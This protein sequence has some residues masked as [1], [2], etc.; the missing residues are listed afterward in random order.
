[1]K[2]KV[3]L[4]SCHQPRRRGFA[5]DDFLCATTSHSG[6]FADA[7]LRQ[8]QLKMSR[9]VHRHRRRLPPVGGDE[10]RGIMVVMTFYSLANETAA[11]LSLL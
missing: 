1:M 5:A 4:L 8:Q 7:A 10:E 11:E 9:A 2:G 6:L 3:F